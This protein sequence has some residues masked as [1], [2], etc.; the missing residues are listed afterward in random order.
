MLQTFT[1]CTFPQ[2]KE[3]IR[4]VR[5]FLF[6]ML[7]RLTSFTRLLEKSPQVPNYFKLAALFE[8]NWRAA[9]GVISTNAPP[10]V[11]SMILRSVSINPS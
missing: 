2:A 7:E 8:I 9:S 11:A 5:L 4:E 1:C 10:L 6:S 3:G